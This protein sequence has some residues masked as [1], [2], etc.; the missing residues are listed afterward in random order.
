MARGVNK[1]IIIGNLG[2]DPDVRFMPNGNAVANLSVATDESYKDKNTGQ[3]VPKTE[4]HRVVIFGKLAEIA[5]QYLTKGAQVYIEGKLETRKWQAQ[6]GGDRYTTE[7]KAFS[8]QMLDSK[9]SGQQQQQQPRPAQ[10]ASAPAQ[11]GKMPEP[12][13]DFD[14]D[15]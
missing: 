8:M 3:M 4:W 15:K 10:S 11:K 14:D 7:I 6:D 13:D 5:G 1:A 2:N 9:G 12:V